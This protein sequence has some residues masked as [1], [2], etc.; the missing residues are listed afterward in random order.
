MQEC[1]VVKNQTQGLD[2]CPGSALYLLCSLRQVTSP[3]G[4]SLF[5]SA[6]W[7]NGIPTLQGQWNFKSPR[8]SAHQDT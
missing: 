1:G 2:S 7:G 6:K 3:L 8:P 4:T 5:S